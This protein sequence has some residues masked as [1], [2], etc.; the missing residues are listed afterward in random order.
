[1]LNNCKTTTI[2][3]SM[4]EK[5]F[6][7]LKKSIVDANGITSVSDRTINACAEKLSKQITEESQIAEAIKPD[8]EILKEVAGNISA[9]AAEAV[10]N[11][12]PVEK[13]PDV[14]PVKKTED[15]QA[16]I[17][18]GIAEALKPLSEKIAGYEAK[19]KLTSRQTI[20]ANKA[21]ELGIPEWRQKEGFII[22]EEADEAAI[23]SYLTTVKTNIVAAGLESEKTGF[24]MSTTADKAKELAKEWAGNLPD[25]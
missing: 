19:E 20:I 7:A 14:P 17:Q 3:S 25:A 6:Q 12:K 22:P 5:I 11:V 23:T 15:I 10:K 2:L 21:K 18:A 13:T 16:L 9:V 1:M 4:K 24:S 8:V